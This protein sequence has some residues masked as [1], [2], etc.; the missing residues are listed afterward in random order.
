MP[1]RYATNRGE[2][3]ADDIDCRTQCVTDRQPNT[4]DILP[5]QGKQDFKPPMLRVH[6]E[7]LRGQDIAP[8][9]PW[10]RRVH[11]SGSHRWGEIYLNLSSNGLSF[12]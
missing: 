11:T 9:R 6:P 2:P 5:A 1:N 7:I 3:A 4:I 8:R 10:S 12:Q